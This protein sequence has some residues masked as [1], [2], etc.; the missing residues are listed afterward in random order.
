MEFKGCFCI[1]SDYTHRYLINIGWIQIRIR[2]DLTLL[3]GSGTRKIKSWIRIRNKSFRI[4]NTAVSV[5][6]RSHLFWPG[7]RA[8]PIWSEPES[9][10]AY[11]TSDFRSRNRP[12]KWRLRNTAWGTSLLPGITKLSDI[13]IC[14]AELRSKKGATTAPALTLFGGKINELNLSTGTFSLLSDHF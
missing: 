13:S 3:P 9:A 11:G 12:K 10:T 8:D 5:W 4:H 6:S 7:A 2:M 1:I 14:G